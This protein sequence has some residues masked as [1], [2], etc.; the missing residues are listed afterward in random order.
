MDLSR[1]YTWEA[2][3]KLVFG[4]GCSRRAGE[5]LKSL[6]GRKVLLVTDKG[7][8]GAGVLAGIL[9]GLDVAGVACAIY[10]DVEPDPP[11]RCVE[12]AA[13]LYRLESCDCLL[14]VGGGSS[15]DTAKAAGAV[16]ANPAV[17]IRNMEGRGKIVEPIPPLV[18][19]PTT[20]GTGSE[21][22]MG[23]VI[24]VSENR[25]K[26]GIGSPFL[27]PRVALIDSALLVGLPGP[28]VASTGMDALCHALE[29]YVNLSAN[30]F[31]DAVDLRAIGIISEW[32]RPAVANRNLEAM[33]NMVLA[34]T[35][36]GMGFANTRLTIVHSMSQPVSGY[37]SVP[38]GV[39]N[40]ILLP[41]VMEF[42]LIGN[43]RRFADV[44]KAM[45]Q[46]TSD[47]TVME[48]ARL[49]VKAVRELAK[50]VGM[51]ETFKG[52]GV[53]KEHLEAMIDDTL[54]NG[55]VPVN[56]VRVT[57]EAVREIFLKVIV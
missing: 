44:A 53:T 54:R 39:A 18:A 37:Y 33:S 16:V 45:G 4:P 50:D 48:A 38:H 20:C 27:F 25:Y 7:V 41:H 5:E 29:S 17:D 21:V 40:A 23:A 46:D 51:P 15:I 52:Y 9:E 31:S 22:T 8:K 3:T 11:I 32:L 55:S 30:P 49:S 28:V 13:E 6:G 42:N 19:V 24:T 47:L 35:M 34:S 10:E 57:R 36:A 26:M 1:I 56:P 2:P 14:A 43:A 12:R